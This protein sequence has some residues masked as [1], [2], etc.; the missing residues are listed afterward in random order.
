MG[1]R[2]KYTGVLPGPL[3]GLLVT[4]LSPPHYHAA[5]GM[6]PYTLPWTI[7]PVSRL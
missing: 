6:M 7:T 4:L 3:E 2:H 5:L 1:G